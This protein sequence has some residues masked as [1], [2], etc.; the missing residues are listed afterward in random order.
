MKRKFL[1]FVTML[2]V[3]VCATFA[4]STITVKGNVVSAEDQE[5]IIGASV[6]VVGTTKGAITD[7]D[8]N[9]QIADVPSSA[10]L[11]V[12][13]VGMATQTVKVARNVKVQLKADTQV[14]DEVVVTAMGIQR[15]AKAIGYATA[16]VNNEELTMAKGSDATAALS[17][18]VSGLQ[19]NITSAALDQETRITLR[20]AR[21]FK[22]DNSALL[23]LDGV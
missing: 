8:G 23:V 5:P 3:G 20:G 10:Q 18:K 1:A 17:G 2:I 7:I 13:F 6:L 16:K 22:G 4:Q 19:I 12:S 21:S 14:M 9:F 15:Q 11:R